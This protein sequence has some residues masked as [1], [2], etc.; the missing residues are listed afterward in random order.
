MTVRVDC[1]DRRLFEV[2]SEVIVDVGSG[3][4]FSVFNG[5]DKYRFL[6]YTDEVMTCVG[7]SFGI[8]G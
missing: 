6:E 1:K 5:Y 2:V 4:S 8:M 3:D 7:L